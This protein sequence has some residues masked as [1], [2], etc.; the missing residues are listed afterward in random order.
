M[1]NDLVIDVYLN[2][3]AFFTS[4]FVEDFDNAG[5]FD[6]FSAHAAT[7]SVAVQQRRYWKIKKFSLWVDLIYF[8]D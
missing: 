2:K 7:K 4:G 8:E 5:N 1:L 3:Y 6:P